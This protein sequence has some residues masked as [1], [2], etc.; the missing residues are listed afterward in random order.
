MRLPSD[1]HVD[2]TDAPLE[3]ERQAQEAML[4][5]LGGAPDKIA[6]DGQIHRFKIEGDKGTQKAGW[7]IFYGDRIPAGAFGN[8]RTDFSQKWHANAG[9][10]LTEAERASIEESCRRAQAI[11]DAE[12]KE[13]NRRAAETCQKIWEGAPVA[14]ENH[15][16]LQAKKIKPHG[17]RVTGDGRLIMPI[18]TGA[19][20]TSLQY[21]GADGKKEF[22]GGGAVAGGYFRILGDTATRYIVEGFATGASV[23][24]A[25]GAEVWVALNAGNLS[26]V[27]EWLREHMPED[28]F[29]FVGDND[30]SGTGQAKA[31]TAAEAIGARVVI[32]PNIGDANDYAASGKDLKALLLGKEACPMRYWWELCESPNPI[33]WLIE[34]WIPRESQVMLLGTSGVGKS[35]V[36]LDMALSIACPQVAGWHGCNIRHAPVVYLAGE[37]EPGVAKRLCAWKLEHPEVPAKTGDLIIRPLAIILDN[38]GDTEIS[39]LIRE[40]N[41]MRVAPAMIVIDPTIRF[42]AGDENKAQDVMKLL[43]ACSK[44]YQVFSCTVMLVHHTGL[45]DSAQKRARGSSA[46]RAAQDSEMVVG[47]MSE[48]GEGLISLTQTKSKD[49]VC[50][51][52]ITFERVSVNLPGWVNEFGRQE[53]SCVLRQVDRSNI[54]SKDDEP[55]LTKNQSF[56]WQTFYK[57]CHTAGIQNGQKQFIGVTRD[58]W[59]DVFLEM[60]DASNLSAKKMAFKRAVETLLKKDLICEENGVFKLSGFASDIVAQGISMSLNKNG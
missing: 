20:I 38:E 29:V 3:P 5:A 43:Q 8:W 37:G 47:D 35:F 44:L 24:E 16:Y 13:R 53:T 12:R 23:H 55:K 57:A 31:K 14:P 51:A 49:S 15:P 60:S 50:Q 18:Y 9:H 17:L 36:A 6:F 7:Y 40:I 32:P 1:F 52:P 59:R 54:L 28:T 33:R 22:H 2:T 46:W 26:K 30:E 41:D 39:A 19:D 21:I 27:G 10:E 4:S 42:M 25:T 34:G 56:A 45:L 58:A 48:E 11:R